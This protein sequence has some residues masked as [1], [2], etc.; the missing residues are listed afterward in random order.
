MKKQV[1]ALSLGI[2]TIAVVA[3]K[4]E[5]RT[6]EKAINKQD[7]AGAIATIN[8]VE[9]MIANADAKYKSK[10]YFLKGKALAGKKDYSSKLI[11]LY[12]LEF[13]PRLYFVLRREAITQI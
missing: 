4:K 9:G 2:M 3:Q 7:Y 1:L 11:F 6:A 10:F 8:S 12:K 5:L 13:Q